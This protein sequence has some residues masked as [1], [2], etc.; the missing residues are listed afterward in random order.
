MTLESIN[1]FPET[2]YFRCKSKSE[3]D[4]QCGGFASL[5]I[6]I[7]LLVILSIKLNEAFKRHSIFFN[8]NTVVTLEP[9][10][11]TISTKQSGLHHNPYMLAIRSIDYGC[12]SIREVKAYNYT[13]SNLHTNNSSVA[14]TSIPLENC[15]ADHFSTI[16]NVYTKF[17]RLG[18]SNWLC[19]PLNETYEIG[20]SWDVSNTYKALLIQANC[21]QSC[22]VN[23][24]CGTLAVYQLSTVM[25]P[26]NTNS[27]EYF[28]ERND[29]DLVSDTWNYYVGHLD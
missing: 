15:T 9:P 6:I 1:L 3:L 14:N 23:N 21:I 11:S 16:P 20:G 19:F 26:H 10:M 8:S 12:P 5:L 17:S 4:H 27:F 28:M 29:M 18:M 13:Y 2:R 24:N 7:T 22:G 25:N